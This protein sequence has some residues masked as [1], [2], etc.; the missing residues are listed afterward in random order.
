MAFPF[1]FPHNSTAGAAMAASA[2]LF[3]PKTPGS[4]RLLDKMEQIADHWQWLHLSL[5][6]IDNPKDRQYQA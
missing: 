1:L 3:R 2:V 6:G 5:R 4:S